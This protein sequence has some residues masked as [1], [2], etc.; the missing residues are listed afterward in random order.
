MPIAP[1]PGAEPEFRFTAPSAQP[2][3][4]EQVVAKHNLKLGD[5]AFEPHKARRNVVNERGGSGYT[6]P[7]SV[8][9]GIAP[10]AGAVQASGRILPPSVNRSSIF[11]FESGTADHE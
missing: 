1:L 2:S 8:A 7:I 5:P 11:E 6:V 4:L 3:G 9:P 10:E